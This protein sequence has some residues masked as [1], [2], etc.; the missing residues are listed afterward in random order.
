MALTFNGLRKPELEDGMYIMP[1]MKHKTSGATGPAT[2]SVK[3]EGLLLMQQYSTIVAHVLG[4]EKVD[5]VPDSQVRTR[6]MST[7][8]L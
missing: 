7:C 4:F 2:L 1:I 8:I 5:D 6:C 3:P